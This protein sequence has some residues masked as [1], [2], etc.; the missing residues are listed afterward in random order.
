MNALFFYGIT[1]PPE[2]A[3]VIAKF[4]ACRPSMR[5]PANLRE[6][7][8]ALKSHP[9][10]NSCKAE[11]L[12]NNKWES[13][14]AFPRSHRGFLLRHPRTLATSYIRLRVLLRILSE[15]LKHTE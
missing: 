11:D 15:I 12:L 3:F 2:E 14:K 1:L 10:K 8:A 4:L 5:L 7:F 6:Q 13:K 9:M